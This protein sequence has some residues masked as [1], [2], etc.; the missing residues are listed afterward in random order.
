VKRKVSWKWPR[1]ELGCRAKGKKVKDIG[2]EFKPYIKA[3]RN[4]LILNETPRCNEQVETI[5]SGNNG[6]K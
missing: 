6:W 5:F 4:E 1:P 2:K 3:C